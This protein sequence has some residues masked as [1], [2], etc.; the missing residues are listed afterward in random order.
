MLG[1]SLWGCGSVDRCPVFRTVFIHGCLTYFSIY[2]DYK[3][4]LDSY[5]L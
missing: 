3:D 1:G 2:R 4:L 5:V